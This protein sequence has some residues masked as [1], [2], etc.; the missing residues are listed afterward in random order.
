MR[1]LPDL[2]GFAIFAKVAQLHS[3]A[4][5]ATELNLSKST[6]SKAVARLESRLK[7]RPFHRTSRRLS[8]RRAASRL[9][10]RRL[11]SSDTTWPRLSKAS[12]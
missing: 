2:E 4:A 11:P 10:I 3:F 1:R 7:V 6:V 12:P 5:A 8:L 9:A